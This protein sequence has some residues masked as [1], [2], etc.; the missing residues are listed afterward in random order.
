[1]VKIFQDNIIEITYIKFVYPHM[2]IHI[3]CNYI[4]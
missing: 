1:M 3:L 2:D 4:S